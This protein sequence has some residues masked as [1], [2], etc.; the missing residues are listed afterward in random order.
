MGLEIEEGKGQVQETTKDNFFK[1]NQEV[2]NLK[3]G[4]GKEEP[5]AAKAQD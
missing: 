2:Q 3:A 4:V 1:S 5:T